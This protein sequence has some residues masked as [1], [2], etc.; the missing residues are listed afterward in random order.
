MDT[1]TRWLHETA[2]GNVSGLHLTSSEAVA[3]VDVYVVRLAVY[4]FDRAD[5][6]VDSYRINAD[7]TS[8]TFD[9]NITNITCPLDNGKHLGRA[10]HG[11]GVLDR[12]PVELQSVILIQSDLR[13]L[14]DFRRVNRRAMEVVD[15]LPEYQSILQH[16]PASLRAVLSTELGTFIT[17]QKLYNTL[18]AAR[19]E[20]CSQSAD[21]IYLLTCCR[22]CLKCLCWC[23]K[24]CPIT[25][26]DAVR[27]YALPSRLLAELS[28]I[29][30]AP[31]HYGTDKVAYV[32]RRLLV[33]TWS[34]Y[35]VAIAH[36]GESRVLYR[37]QYYSDPYAVPLPSI[38]PLTTFQWY[39]ELNRFMAT[40]PAP[41]IQD[42]GRQRS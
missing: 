23:T 39:P 29:R 7:P 21:F 15:S 25:T 26:D 4:V 33:D 40:I 31:G 30:S 32:D 38:E 1:A 36:W 35:T 22:V 12:L 37:A 10:R 34:A 13:T 2:H 8:E 20:C 9:D 19:C 28:T 5:S 42:Q 14:T 6:L 11:L 24:Y 17:C 18:C 16:S 27:L 3:A 41:L